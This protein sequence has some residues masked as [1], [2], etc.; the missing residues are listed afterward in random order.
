[1]NEILKTKLFSLL[2]ESSQV[3]NEEMQ[4]A[5]GEFIKHIWTVSQ[6]DLNYPDIYRMLNN[7]R[8]ELLFLQ[9]LHRYEQGKKRPK[10][11]L[12]SESSLVS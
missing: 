7:T 5:Y 6:S 11:C 10:N 12:F 3:M 1:M 4:T 9:T 8:T 2:A